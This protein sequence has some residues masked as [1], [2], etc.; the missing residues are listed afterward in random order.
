MGHHK[1]WKAGR[2]W[3]GGGGW[4]GTPEFG[5][6]PRPAKGEMLA[7]SPACPHQWPH[8][9]RCL[10]FL[11]SPLESLGEQQRRP[12]TAPDCQEA[13][14]AVTPDVCCHRGAQA[15]GSR[16]GL[17]MGPSGGSQPCLLPE[18]CGLWFST[19]TSLY[20]IDRPAHTSHSA[21]TTHSHIHITLIQAQACCILIHVPH[22]RTSC[23]AMCVTHM[24]THVYNS[25][26][27]T[28]THYTQ[29]LYHIYTSSTHEHQTH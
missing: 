12:H 22:C 26:S 18:D 23:T 13:A 8:Q 20:S 11:K 17:N 29:T 5:A 3:T 4:A 24:C 27:Y 7:N 10:C 14:M 16:G 19:F 28:N 21:Q 2:T 15:C 9:W 1:A 6:A 25:K